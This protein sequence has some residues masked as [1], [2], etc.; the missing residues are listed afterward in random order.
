L[1]FSLF[2]TESAR[3]SRRIYRFRDIKVRR[4]MTKLPKNI[5]VTVEN[6]A[7]RI[8]RVPSQKQLEKQFEPYAIEL[9]KLVYAWNRL[10]EKLFDLFWAVTGLQNGNIANAI[11]HSID[12]DRAQRQMLR[13]AAQV[14]FAHEKRWRELASESGGSISRWK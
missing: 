2:A 6:A 1:T 7:G 8:V 9:G 13:K 10:H 4:P 3:A 12:R 11:W 14:L 5:G